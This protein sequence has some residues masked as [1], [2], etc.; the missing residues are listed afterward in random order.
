[1]TP[2]TIAQPSPLATKRAALVIRREQLL[3]KF[4]ESIRSGN[5][6]RA[7]RLSA[8]AITMSQ[9]VQTL[10]D[11]ATR[12]E[13]KRRSDIPRFVVSSYFLYD[14]FRKL[15]ADSKE[16]L[17]FITGVEVDGSLILNQ[18]LDLEHDRRTAIG[19]EAN[20]GFTHRL[21]IQLDRFRHRLLAHAHSHPGTGPD[22][23]APSGIDQRFQARLE[24]AGHV[25]VAAIFS[26]DGFVR[27]FRL[28]GA[29]EIVVFGE[30]VEAY[31]PN[32][33]RLTNLSEGSR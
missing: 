11:L 10:D 22:A 18:I 25:A 17:S 6:G 24:H 15:T 31:A 20:Q 26:R 30:G 29:F 32:L 27:F 7:R 3:A 5:N 4:A 16:Q 23:T 9:F 14:C 21:L 8:E 1:M 13:P 33:F 19:V 28:Q 2:P 12:M